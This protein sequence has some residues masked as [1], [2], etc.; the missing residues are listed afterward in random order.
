MSDGSILAPMKLLLERLLL[1]LK[2]ISRE[3][4]FRYNVQELNARAIW[5]ATHRRTDL[6]QQYYAV[7]H[8][9]MRNE[10]GCPRL[11][12]GN[13]QFSDPGAK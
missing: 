2:I 13:P 5:H 12:G 11:R 6:A 8:D 4:I 3:R 9:L 1:V 10:H 7:V